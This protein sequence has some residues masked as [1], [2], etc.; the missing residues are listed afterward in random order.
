[1]SSSSDRRMSIQGGLSSRA[2]VGSLHV[3]VYC[4]Q[5]RMNGSSG[6]SRCRLIRPRVTRL[7][8]SA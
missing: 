1:M 5:R 3:S 4:S 2:G 6:S 7:N 8:S